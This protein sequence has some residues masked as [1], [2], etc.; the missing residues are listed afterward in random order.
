M[1]I[2]LAEKAAVT[3]K[4]SPQPELGRGNGIVY[5]GAPSQFGFG[6]E[7]RPATDRDE[8]AYPPQPAGAEKGMFTTT[9]SPKQNLLVDDGGADP[10][11]FDQPALFEPQ[12]PIWLPRDDLG[13]AADEVAHLRSLGIDASTDGAF[14]TAKGK[15]EVNVRS[16]PR[17]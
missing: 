3:A 16:C 8:S 4:S 5:D 14:L 9:T 17:T 12:R 1:P 7:K 10:H 11:A 15:V 13:I 6:A 2:S